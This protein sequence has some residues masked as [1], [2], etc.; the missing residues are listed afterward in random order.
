MS[1]ILVFVAALLFAAPGLAVSGFAQSVEQQLDAAEQSLRTQMAPAGV[2]VERVAPDQIVVRMPADITFDFDSAVIKGAFRLRVYDLARV[3]GE[4][5]NLRVRIV[6]HA[7][8]M[9]PDDYN[10]RLSERRAYAVGNALLDLG[11]RRYRIDASGM[12][13]WSPI[14]S[15]ATEWGRARNRRVEIQ[16]VGD[17]RYSEEPR[18]GDPRFE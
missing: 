2:D 13:E 12:G 7:D 10:Q 17:R 14:E 3:L 5:P 11:I 8:A 6:G 9:G 4:H 15:N 16:I 18:F 1:R